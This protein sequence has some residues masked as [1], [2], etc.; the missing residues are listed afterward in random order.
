M[1]RNNKRRK[2]EDDMQLVQIGEKQPEKMVS[3]REMFEQLAQR[4][5]EM[6][7]VA[8]QRVEKLSRI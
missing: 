1:K 8:R 5:A 7:R 2:H 3:I 6:V 4:E